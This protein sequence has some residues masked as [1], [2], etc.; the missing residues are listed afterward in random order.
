MLGAMKGWTAVPAACAVLLWTFSCAGNSLSEPSAAASPAPPQASQCGPP[1][2]REQLLGILVDLLEVPS[3]EQLLHDYEVSIEPQDCQSSVLLTLREPLA[4]EPLFFVID[5]SGRVTNPPAC[6]WLGDKANCKLELEGEPLSLG[7]LRSDCQ[8]QK[9]WIGAEHLPWAAWLTC[10]GQDPRPLTHPLDLLGRVDIQDQD[11][12]LEVLR[13]FSS[14]SNCQLFPLNGMV[15]ITLA[16][17]PWKEKLLPELRDR[18]LFH[19]PQVHARSE[20]AF[21][22][23]ETGER[24]TCTRTIYVV[25]RLAAFYDGNVYDVVEELTEDGLYSLVSKELVLHDIGSLGVQ[26]QPASLAAPD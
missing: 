19:Q 10:D 26:H 21:C 2:S 9:A 25:R 18:G 8:I 12:A 24:Y 7:P 3:K 20:N 1:L 16:A 22:F 14:P 23:S 5:S 11:G 6:W 13:F 17:G 4:V 15:D